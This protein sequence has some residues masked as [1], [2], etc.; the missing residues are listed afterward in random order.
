MTAFRAKSK[1]ENTS[2]MAQ[3]QDINLTFLR[4][5]IAELEALGGRVSPELYDK[6]KSMKEKLIISIAKWQD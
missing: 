5:Q 2:R 3:N 4:N 1:E 6:S